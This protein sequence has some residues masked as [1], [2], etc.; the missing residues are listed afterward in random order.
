MSV[1][2]AE[3]MMFE[4]IIFT[5]CVMYNETGTPIFISE[6]KKNSQQFPFMNKMYF[7]TPDSFFKKKKVATKYMDQQLSAFWEVGELDSVP[8][9]CMVA[10]SLE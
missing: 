9:N 1:Y 5:P 7:Y 3:K 8:V 4:I 10:H 6:S 2:S